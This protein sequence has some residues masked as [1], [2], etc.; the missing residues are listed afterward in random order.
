MVTLS[1]GVT[2]FSGN[3]SEFEESILAVSQTAEEAKNIN[4]KIDNENYGQK[5]SVQVLCEETKKLHDGV[6]RFKL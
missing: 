6:K 1:N 3:K 4:S 2:N 5:A